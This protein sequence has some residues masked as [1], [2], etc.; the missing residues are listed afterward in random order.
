MPIVPSL[1]MWAGMMPALALPGEMRP[2]QFGPM[3]RVFPSFSTDGDLH[4][5]ERRDALGDAHRERHAASA[6]S[7]IASAAERRR[8]E[9]DGGVGAGLRDGLGHRI[10]DGPA[11]VRRAALA[12]R[13]AADHGGAVRRGRLRVERALAAGEAL[14][15]QACRL[16][17]QDCHVP[18]YPRD[19]CDDLRGAFRHRVGRREIEPAVLEHLLAR[20]RRWCLPSG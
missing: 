12:R 1:Q 14:H 10:E 20:S 7:R 2:G 11:L 6:A 3:S 13:D 16:V 8:H 9:D 15:E 17:N 4:H 18:P 5:V 19:S